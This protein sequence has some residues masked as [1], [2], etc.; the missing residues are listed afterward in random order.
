MYM[1]NLKLIV[2]R[3]TNIA[4]GISADFL[5]CVLEHF[6][7]IVNGK[8]KGKAEFTPRSLITPWIWETVIGSLPEKNITPELMQSIKGV[9][10]K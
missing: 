3:C 4:P 1:E 2:V 6:R 10:R 9:F 5:R 7:T 8:L